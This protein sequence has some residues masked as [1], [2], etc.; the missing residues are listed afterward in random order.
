MIVVV[1]V[2]I[3]CEQIYPFLLDANFETYSQK[4]S[5]YV[6]IY[7]CSDVY[8]LVRCKKVHAGAVW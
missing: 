4:F 8:P 6:W 1:F 3:L 2:C 7:T 5:V